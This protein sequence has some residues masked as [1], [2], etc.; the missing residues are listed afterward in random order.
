M[1]NNQKRVKRSSGA[2]AAVAAAP[3]GPSLGFVSPT[4]FVELPSRGEFYP[5]DHPL[6]KQ[7]TVEIRFMTAKDEDILSSQALLKKGLAIDRLIESLLVSDLDSRSLLLGDRNAILIAARISG[8]GS[9]YKFSVPCKACRTVNNIEYD[10][11]SAVITDKCFDEKFLRENN[12]VYNEHTAT[13]DLVLPSSGVE[14]GICPVDGHGEKILMSEN[15]GTENSVVTS[16]LSS[17]VAKVNNSFEFTDV[18]TFIDSMPARDSK[19]LRRLYPKLVPNISLRHDFLCKECLTS[20]DT[21]VP[22][23]AAFFWPE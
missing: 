13:L 4:E 16:V 8:Y 23:T 18:A 17:F 9:D 3:T 14:I 10:L 6:H 2:P 11:R 1:R 12:I 22:L 7:E 15:R 19:F 20:N 21:E 5:E